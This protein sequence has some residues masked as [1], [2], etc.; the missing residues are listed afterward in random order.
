MLYWAINKGDTMDTKGSTTLAVTGKRAGII[1][2]TVTFIN[3][4]IFLVVA[5]LA[6]KEDGAGLFLVVAAVIVGIL[7]IPVA[8]NTLLMKRVARGDFQT[9][10]KH[11]S[12]SLLA[13]ILVAMTAILTPLAF[14]FWTLP[15]LFVL[16]FVVN[17]AYL[18]VSIVFIYKVNKNLANSAPIAK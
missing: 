10:N 17:T 15:I 11:I 2:F 13:N 18:V 14:L 12:I 7:A 4:L 1:G 8:A 5:T 6:A 16:L 3:L 9:I